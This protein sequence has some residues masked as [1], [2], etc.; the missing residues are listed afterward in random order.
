MPPASPTPAR[1]RRIVVRIQVG[2]DRMA[3]SDDP[4]FLLLEGPGGR[5]FRLLPARGTGLRR[6]SED[7]YVL[8]APEDPETNVAHPDLNDPNAP[9][10][11]ADALTGIALR[12]GL[13]PIPNVRGLGEMDDRLQLASAEVELHV[14]GEPRPRHWRLAGPVWLGL[15]CGLSASLVR[16]E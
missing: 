6:G 8:A 3:G 16:A 15:I 2:N 7:R 9:P 10:L 5:E 4:L 11:D 1:V 13:E 12:K 14:E